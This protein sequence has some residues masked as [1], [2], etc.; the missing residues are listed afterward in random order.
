[1]IKK[2]SLSKL[3]YLVS[4]ISRLFRMV[5]IRSEIPTNNHTRNTKDPGIKKSIGTSTKKLLITVTTKVRNDEDN[6]ITED[7]QKYFLILD[8]LS[9]PPLELYIM[10]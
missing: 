5:K 4:S 7:I 9:P 6:S 10:F 8:T 1:M 3:I 2:D